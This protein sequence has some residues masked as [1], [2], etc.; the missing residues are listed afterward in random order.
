MYTFLCACTFSLFLDVHLGVK[1]AESFHNSIMLYILKNNQTFQSGCTL[2]QH[3]QQCIRVPVS[4]LPLRYLLLPVLAIATLVD[5]RWYLIVVLIYLSLMT[6]AVEHFFMWL[7]VICIFSLVKCLFKKIF[8]PFLNS[9][10]WVF[11]VDL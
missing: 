6:T 4:L 1:I 7:L 2:L 8:C 9:I 11:L 10:I 5:V 3:P